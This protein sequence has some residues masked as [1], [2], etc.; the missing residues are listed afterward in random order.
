[1]H[2]TASDRPTGGYESES[3]SEYWREKETESLSWEGREMVL[4]F[5]LSTRGGAMAKTLLLFSVL[6][7]F[8]LMRRGGEVEERMGGVVR[9]GGSTTS[10]GVGG[11]R[12]G[13][14]GGVGGRGEGGREGMTGGWVGG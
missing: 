1:M 2:H 13:V 12:E 4:V 8:T 14:E 3:E 7:G 11:G 9:S 6:S 5:R 10:G